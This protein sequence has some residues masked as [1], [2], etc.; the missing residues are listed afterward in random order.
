MTDLLGLPPNAAAHGAVI[1]QMMLW[2]HILMLI[3]FVGWGSFFCFL[4]FRFRAG[5]NK[6]ADYVGVK[7]K[8]SKYMEIAVA[9][10][11]AAL[12][13]G[14]AIPLWHE[15]VNEFPDDKDA[16]IVHVI[17]EQ[18]AWNIHYPGPDGEFGE[19][20]VSLVDNETNPIGLDREGAGADDITTINQLVLPVD[21][22][23]IVYLSSKDVIHSFGIPQMR[24]KQ[25]IIPGQQI[26]VWFVPT[27]TGEYEIACAQLCGLGHYRMRGFNKVKTQAEYDAWLVE[28]AA[29]L[30]EEDEDAW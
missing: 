12:L 19:R 9:L 18:F 15:R 27:Q 11:E 10:F 7:S 3:L 26:P 1:D 20:K 23:V 22:P 24:T 29:E 16:V 5:K 6:V 4:L 17:A 8:G 14:F 28:K 13:F 25:D 21:K 2:V 30:A